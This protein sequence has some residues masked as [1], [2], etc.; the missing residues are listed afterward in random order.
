MNNRQ[1]SETEADKALNALIY[2]QPANGAGLIITQ[3]LD[4]LKTIYN[5]ASGYEAAAIKQ[6]ITDLIEEYK[7][8]LNE[9]S[10]KNQSENG[11]AD[12]E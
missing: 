8:K 5:Q 10:V 6:N 3:D 11:A 4:R 9:D 1:S 12:N 7:R 2:G